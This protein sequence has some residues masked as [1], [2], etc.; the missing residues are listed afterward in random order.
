MLRRLSGVLSRE[1]LV[2]AYAASKLGAAS[3]LDY[4]RAL[5]SAKHNKNIVSVIFGFFVAFYG[6]ILAVNKSSSLSVL[7]FITVLFMMLIVAS[8]VS[9]AAS[10]GSGIR[11]ALLPLGLDERST[12]LVTGLGIIRVLDTPLIVVLLIAS[13]FGALSG[14]V[15]ELVSIIMAALMGLFIALVVMMALTKAFQL[16][17]LKSLVGNVIKVA[18]L[19]SLALPL[20]MSTMVLSIGFKPTMF[21]RTYVP[22]L[23]LIGVQQGNIA[24][25]LIAATVTVVLG[26]SGYVALVRTT[27][28]LS[29]P[30][31]SA[32]SG[33]M[34]KI[35]V[36]RK[37]LEILVMN[38]KQVTRTPQL[39]SLAAVPLVYTLSMLI[40]LVEAPVGLGNFT[41]AFDTILFPVAFA[42]TSIPMAVYYAELRGYEQLTMLPITKFHRAIAK[43]ALASIFY[44]ISAVVVMVM[45]VHVFPSL[46]TLA[47]Y[48]A[49][50]TITVAA[51]ALFAT[52][53]FYRL[54]GKIAV[55]VATTMSSVV[56][57]ATNLVL[58]G[59]PA[60]VMWVADGWVLNPTDG[61][62]IAAFL[63]SAMAELVAAFL[64]VRHIHAD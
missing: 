29:Q 40:L 52:V 49:A 44:L 64:V 45:L 9:Y 10:A 24:A 38:S 55:G 23:N 19:I 27:A 54:A 48:A 28:I 5:Q 30:Q 8:Q 56:Y 18:A 41:I 34:P 63:M 39:L 22:V 60:A 59:V 15:F 33:E 26:I 4:N 57:G 11:D 53:Y 51:A 6:L 37:S 50:Y 42:S 32:A 43:M 17:S 12:N 14:G 13:V 1:L 31:S 62:G 7:V 2:Q 16:F 61:I 36:R 35:K 47:P 58:F 25:L 46:V 3:G 20:A 21:E